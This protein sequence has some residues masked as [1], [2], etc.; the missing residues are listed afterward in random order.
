M[1]GHLTHGGS[2]KEVSKIPGSGNGFPPQEF[3]V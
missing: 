1:Y 3:V 2:K